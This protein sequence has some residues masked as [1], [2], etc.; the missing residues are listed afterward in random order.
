M[1]DDEDDVMC[2]TRANSFVH[3]LDEWLTD[4]ECV[5]STVDVRRMAQFLIFFR[6]VCLLAQVDLQ[7]IEFIIGFGT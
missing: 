6:C 4:D 1:A 7:T 2:S 5:D 3:D